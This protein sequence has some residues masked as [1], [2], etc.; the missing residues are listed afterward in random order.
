MTEA[1][2]NAKT[3]LYIED[4]PGMIDLVRLILERRGYRMLSALD[5][6]SGIE[7][8]EQERPDLVL[9]DIMMPQMDGWEVFRHIK[10]SPE[11]ENIPIIVVTARTQPIDVIL[12]R[13]V[14]KVD[15]YIK[16]PFGPQEILRSIEKILRDRAQDHPA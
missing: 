12:A 7:I 1:S 8:V 6:A 4:E 3:I 10:S 15:D 16:K 5:A 11:L 2:A 14:A 9:L 13:H